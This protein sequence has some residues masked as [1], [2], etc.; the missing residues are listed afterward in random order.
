[1]VYL[2]YTSCLRYTILVGNPRNT[3]PHLSHP[4]HLVRLT[5]ACLTSCSSGN[6]NFSC[7]SISL[8]T[9]SWCW[10]GMRS[11]GLS[12]QVS[13]PDDPTV[14]LGR[15]RGGLVSGGEVVRASSR[16][17]GLTAA[18]SFFV[19]PFCFFRRSSLSWHW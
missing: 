12:S 11:S 17:S 8:R 6:S 1:M 19:G 3:I 13:P 5:V 16:L 10:R 2:Y 7:S 14:E 9:V 18:L 15:P 4:V